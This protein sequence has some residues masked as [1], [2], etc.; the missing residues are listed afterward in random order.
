[1]LGQRGIKTSEPQPSPRLPSLLFICFIG[2]LFSGSPSGIKRLRLVKEGNVVGTWLCA[3]QHYASCCLVPFPKC[4]ACTRLTSSNRLGAF[5]KQSKHCPSP[6][7]PHT[8]SA[9]PRTASLLANAEAEIVQGKGHHRSARGSSPLL[10]L[11]VHLGRG[12]FTRE[13]RAGPLQRLL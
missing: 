11:K 13:P 6:P 12:C 4:S 8:G 1:M 2:N 5:G 10:L 3:I 9:W 7:P